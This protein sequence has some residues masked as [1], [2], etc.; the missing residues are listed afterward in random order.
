[1]TRGKSTAALA[2]AAQA[3]LSSSGCFGVTEAVV[4]FHQ[5]H[6]RG[7]PHKLKQSLSGHASKLSR[8]LSV[9]GS[10][11]CGSDMFQ[12]HTHSGCCLHDLHN[13]VRWGWQVT[14]PRSEDT[15]KE[16]YVGI[17]SFRASMAHVAENL[18]YWLEEVLVGVEDSVTESE[19]SL[20]EFYATL[21]A[22]SDL[23]DRICCDMKLVWE[24]TESKLCVRLPFLT[25][26]GS[27][28]GVMDVLMEM[29]QFPSFTTSRWLSVGSSCRHF[30]LGACTG[31]MSFFH[32]MRNR[33]ALSDFECSAGTQL[34]ARHVTFAAVLGLL[35]Y[36][37]D[38]AT[39]ILLA[40]ARLVVVK[41]EVEQSLEDETIYI[42]QI[43]QH[44][45]QRLA[46]CGDVP[47][48]VLRDRVLCGVYCSRAY[49]FQQSLEQLEQLPWS[50]MMGDVGANLSSL[51]SADTPPPDTTSS[52][53][54]ALGKAGMSESDL[55]R[56]LNLM[57]TATFSTK[58]TERLHASA[59]TV[60]R[61]HA[62][63][64]DILC[65]R[66]FLHSIRGCLHVHSQFASIS[67]PQYYPEPCSVLHMETG[68]L[69]AV[70]FVQI[71]NATITAPTNCAVQ[72]F[73]VSYLLFHPLR[74]GPLLPSTGVQDTIIKHAQQRIHRLQHRMVEKVRGRQMFLGECIRQAKSRRS[75]EVLPRSTMLYAMKEHGRKWEGLAPS[76]RDYYERLA[77]NRRSEL[78]TQIVQDLEHERAALRAHLLEEQL[79]DESGASMAT[80]RFTQSAF[81]TLAELWESKTLRARDVTM[82]RKSA[83]TTPEP[84]SLDA[85]DSLVASGSLPLASPPETLP[86]I[87]DLCRRRDGAL[88]SLIVHRSK[89]GEWTCARTVL[90]CK[91]PFRAVFMH[92]ELDETPEQVSFPSTWSE[93]RACANVPPELQFCYESLVFS[94]GEVFQHCALSELYVY[95]TSAFHSTTHIVPTSELQLLERWLVAWCIPEKAR[96]VAAT[97][98]SRK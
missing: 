97:E 33:G 39:G 93:L 95:P 36:P 74:H 5:V 54:W 19:D 47:G 98:T 51:L 2:S 66:A 9:E 72:F 65:S 40:D 42:E 86:W 43:S 41:S 61:F 81:E 82:L 77:E 31:Y 11:D 16:M 26:K 80:S 70:C 48:H 62:H 38:A 83:T 23:L 22:R 88:T 49:Y 69:A 46:R 87:K 73:Q 92:L 37:S 89:D 29:W 85:I 94:E 27:M 45:W 63:T 3:F 14:Y 67:H 68:R 6:D 8:G 13:S 20:R 44:V 1:M 15:L 84:L 53:I 78:A 21:G 59:A 55:V 32:H 50:L 60:R 96:V 71:K 28:Q 91:N 35:S 4:C 56:A 24:P 57:C 30:L 17:S 10:S 34:T 7:V 25:T 58:T 18:G 52:R 90:L 12:W 79:P 75:V 64:V 76:E